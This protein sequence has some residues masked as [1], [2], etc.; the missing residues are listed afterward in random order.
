M[1]YLVR[2]YGSMPS[3][4]SGIPAE[5]PAEVSTVSDDTLSS[6][7]DRVLFTAE[8]LD[9]Y[10]TEKRPLYD[11]WL[12]SYDISTE[13]EAKFKLIDQKTSDLIADGFE[14][15]PG[16][17]SKFS[18]SIEAQSL[19]L[20]AYQSRNAAFMAYPM[21]WNMKDDSGSIQLLTPEEFEQFYLS[22][23]GTIR[24][25]RDSGTTLKNLVRAAQTKSEVSA[26]LDER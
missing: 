21:E 25:H 8:E 26:I 18:L 7:D 23:L 19:M 24:A 20:G 6:P 15:P 1:K 5:W 11:A 14:Y 22:A 10:K 4:P 9:Q 12:D 2:L 3:N 17:G 16:S 13:K